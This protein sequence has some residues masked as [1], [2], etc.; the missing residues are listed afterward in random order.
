MIELLLAVAI[1]ALCAVATMHAMLAGHRQLTLAE[2]EHTG[3]RS[4]ERRMESI[5]QNQSE[6]ALLSLDGQ[7]D[8]PGTLLN[9]LGEL[10]PMSDQSSSRSIDVEQQT[11][12]VGF[13]ATT[14]IRCLRV[15]VTTENERGA[16]TLV[17]RL[18]PI[19]VLP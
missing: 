17:T 9:A 1:F 14:S 2:D 10:A 5:L 19:E 13:G 12:P 15:T 11:I 4:G 6:A 3:A 7:Y 8:P 18:V 16:V